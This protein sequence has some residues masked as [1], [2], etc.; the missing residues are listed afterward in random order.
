MGNS[1]ASADP[2][3][4]R[5]R[6]TFRVLAVLIGLLPILLL[7]GVFRLGGWGRPEYGDDPY[8]GFSDVKPLFVLNDSG[9]RYEIPN[10]RQ[11][12]FQPESFAASK[13]PNEFRI[14]CFGGST[15]QGRP[16]SIETSF[17]TWLE[18]SLQAADPSPQ[19][20]AVNCGGVSYASY[21]LV[22]IMKESLAYEPDL[23]IVY[24]GHNEFLEDR[25]YADIK[26]TP[27]WRKAI[28]ERL[29]GLRMYG[30]CRSLWQR[31]A[32]IDDSEKRPDRVTLST[33]VDALLDYRG[34]LET[35]HRDDEWRRGVIAHFEHNLRNITRLA[36]RAGVPLILVNPVSNL[37]DSP[38]FKCEPRTDLSAEQRAEL[39]R[40]WDEAKAMDW[41]RLDTKFG[42][43]KRVLA[44]DDR[45][46]DAHFLLGRCYEAMGF[47]EQAKAEYIRAKDEDICPL[48]ILAPMHEII[49]SVAKQSRTTLVDAR[50][51]FEHEEK[52]G[53][54]GDQTLIDH[55]HPRIE[56]HQWIARALLE[57]MVRL[58]MVSLRPAWEAKQQELYDERWKTLEPS[59]FPQSVARL[60]GLRLWAQGRVTRIGLPKSARRPD[61]EIEQRA[62]Q[63]IE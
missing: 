33:E 8:V 53:I 13:Q 40:L 31:A 14:F 26:N 39:E 2:K 54:L 24:T 21:R 48:R 62:F 10:S 49:F 23:F 15:V 19:W 16:Y 32:G 30:V 17:T 25:T 27:A 55:V 58:R 47:T 7:E 4:W 44:I 12:F 61:G 46:A 45:Y 41:D 5:R 57:E 3:T 52:D 34:G 38:P 28:H 6:I 29:I 51:M 35:Y 37:R 59:Y 43:V 36:R 1:A 22:P 56:G 63:G 9:D 60:E 11:T 42:L 50:E 18:L 20:E